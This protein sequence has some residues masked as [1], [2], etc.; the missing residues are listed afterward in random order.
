MSNFL[1]MIKLKYFKRQNFCKIQKMNE[2]SYRNSDKHQIFVSTKNK[3]MCTYYYALHILN[4][5]LFI[6]FVN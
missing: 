1:D 3:S 2:D 5:S 4:F 6:S